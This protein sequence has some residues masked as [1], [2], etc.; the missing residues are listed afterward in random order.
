MTW[1]VNKT[2][3]LDGKEEKSGRIGRKSGYEIPKQISQGQEDR[4]EDEERISGLL[5]DEGKRWKERNVVGSFNI[6]NFERVW[7]AQLE[8]LRNN[9]HIS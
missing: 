6:S 8:K 1:L 9:S 5:G 7:K 3:W 2:F 4:I